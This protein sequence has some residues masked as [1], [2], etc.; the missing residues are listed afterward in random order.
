MS[1]YS[2]RP[3]MGGV[4]VTVQQ[5]QTPARRG[6]APAEPDEAVTAAIEIDAVHHEPP[7]AATLLAATHDLVLDA[8][9][10]E[11]IYEATEWARRASREAVPA[12]AA[13]KLKAY[14]RQPNTSADPN[15]PHADIEV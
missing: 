10:Q 8:Q 12:A 13:R 5:R 6:T 14:E 3:A 7:R 1:G 9:S 2:V 4:T 15:D 11:V